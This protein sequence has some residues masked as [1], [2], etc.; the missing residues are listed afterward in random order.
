MPILGS[1][2]LRNNLFVAPRANLDASVNY[3][4]S[5]SMT[6]SLEGINLTDEYNDRY[7]DETNRISDYR[8]TGREIA[9]GLRWKY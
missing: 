8:H 3:D 7:V 4:I 1:H 2:N 9:I 5:D 6:I